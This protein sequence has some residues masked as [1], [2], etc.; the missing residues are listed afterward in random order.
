MAGFVRRI[1]IVNAVGI[2]LEL[3]IQSVKKQTKETNEKTKVRGH[4]SLFSITCIADR[5]TAPSSV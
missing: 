5:E 4:D 3:G 2:R 1:R